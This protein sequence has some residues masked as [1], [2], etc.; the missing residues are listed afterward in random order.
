MALFVD[1]G[2]T[3]MGG[4]WFGAGNCCVTNTG[5]GVWR[6]A[7]ETF[8]NIG[9]GQLMFICCGP[10][11]IPGGGSTGCAIK[12]CIVFDT[13]TGGCTRDACNC[14]CKGTVVTEIEVFCCGAANTWVVC[15]ENCCKGWGGGIEC[16]R[17]FCGG[18]I[19]CKEI[20]CWSDCCGCGG[21]GGG[22]GK[23]FGGGKQV[24]KFEVILTAPILFGGG[25]G[26]IPTWTLTSDKFGGGTD[27]FGGGTFFKKSGSDIAFSVHMLSFGV[28]ILI[29]SN[30]FGLGISFNCMGEGGGI[31][32]TWIG[33]GGGIVKV[34]IGS[35]CGMLCTCIGFGGGIDDNSTVGIQ[36]GGTGIAVCE[37][38]EP[39]ITFSVVIIVVVWT[40]CAPALWVLIRI[41]VDDR[42]GGGGT[43][44]E[45]LDICGCKTCGGGTF[46]NT[47]GA[48]ITGA[49]VGVG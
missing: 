20:F 5:G 7:F 37:G 47:G 29:M 17:T 44:S 15:E 40:F 21:G 16:T 32:W 31:F 23:M 38:A 28:G 14:V 27:L 19:F 43:T 8:C 12:G 1:G 6:V 35:G 2:G 49:L 4:I 48:T 3:F 18:G 33:A 10:N 39:P 11:P 34:F 9:G 25:G 30:G 22:G 13:V 45:L 26:G 42:E 46:N 24:G 36:G 41:L